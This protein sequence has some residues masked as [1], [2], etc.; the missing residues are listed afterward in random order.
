MLRYK[1]Q[2]KTSLVAINKIAINKI[3]QLSGNSE[4]GD[5]R[6][7]DYNRIKLQKSASRWDLAN[8][9]SAGNLNP[10]IREDMTLRS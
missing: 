4:L 1:I 5:M 10:G 3:A 2:T 7:P 9:Q 8:S 6:K